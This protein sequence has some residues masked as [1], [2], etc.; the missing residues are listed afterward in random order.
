MYANSKFCT[1]EIVLAKNGASNFH[2]KCMEMVNV[3]KVNLHSNQRA[4]K[5]QMYESCERIN[6]EH[7]NLRA[8][9]N[10]EREREREENGPCVQ[11]MVKVF[12]E[13]E[14]ERAVRIK[15]G[16]GKM[17]VCVMIA[18]KMKYGC[19]SACNEIG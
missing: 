7:V 8:D 10:R 6:V 3:F 4:R 13:R 15:S 18:I 11:M 1:A 17:L 16:N 9:S 14:R 19:Y 5:Q 2:R 12:R